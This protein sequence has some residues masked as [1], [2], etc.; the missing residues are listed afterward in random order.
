MDIEKG[1]VQ[2]GKYY[3]TFTYR[4]DTLCEIEQL[5]S[6]ETYSYDEAMQKIE[7]FKTKF[8]IIEFKIVKSRGWWDYIFDPIPTLVEV[9]T[10]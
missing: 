4:I 5:V 3:I 10:S 8:N 1:F 7:L 2:D 6:T 9:R